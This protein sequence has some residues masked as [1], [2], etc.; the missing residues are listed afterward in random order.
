LPVHVNADGGTTGATAPPSSPDDEP[1][2]PL[3]GTYPLDASGP[4]TGGRGGDVVV[5]PCTPSPQPA[6]S[7]TARSAPLQKEMPP[8][9]MTPRLLHPCGK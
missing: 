5:V 9:V 7:A 2:P 1:D 3:P 8:R 4:P 6:A